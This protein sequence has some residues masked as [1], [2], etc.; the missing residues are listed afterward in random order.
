M[1]WRSTSPMNERIKFIARYLTN[2]L[3]MTS[4]CDEFGISRKTGYK[5]VQ[6]YDDGGASALEERSRAPLTHP[7]AYSDDIVNTLVALRQEH[8]RWG[9]RKL[10]VLMRRRHPELELPEPS[11]VNGMLSRRGLLRR[12]GRNKHSSEYGQPLRTYDAPN[13][14]W[15]AD[16]K[17][18]FPVGG[19]RCH[20]LTISDG[21]SRFL[22]GC[23]GLRRP[24]IRPAK[25]VFERV[26]RNYGLPEFIRTDNGAPFSSLA[27]A[28]LSELAV[29]WLRLGIMPERILPGRPDQNGRHERMHRTLKA[30]TASP[31]KSTMRAQ[32][33]RF[34]EFRQE[35]NFERPH[36]GIDQRTPSELYKRSSREFPSRVPEPDY[37]SHFLVERAYSNGHVRLE[38][39][40]W[41]VST[42]LKY[43]L[44]GLEP[45]AD[46]R[47]CV[48]FAKLPLGILDP[49]HHRQLKHERVGRV[50]PLDGAIWR[51][52]PHLA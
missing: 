36:E 26:F 32:Q 21:Y 19:P 16:F 10:L 2:E 11:T 40:S 3:T 30:E 47:W 51:E 28:G 44:L 34:D 41:Y 29:W 45:L 49:K 6:R 39:I 52:R 38:G 4:L 25:L 33:R 37:P 24:S 13:S 20:P 18:H 46:G 35:Y 7:H 1:A 23:E 31:A 12:K 42:A 27:I 50:V 43:E 15:C 8:P 17:G 22:L 48:H 14:V 5:W 9:A